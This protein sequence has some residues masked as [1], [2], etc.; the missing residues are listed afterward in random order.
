MEILQFI[1]GSIFGV[2][3][4]IT[5]K[6]IINLRSDYISYYERLDEFILLPISEYTF[7][8]RTNHFVKIVYN[9]YSFYVD[10]LKDELNIFYD[11]ELMIYKTGDNDKK[12]E[13]LFERFNVGFDYDIYHNITIINNTIISNNIINFDINPESENIETIEYIPSMDEILDKISKYGI[14]NLTQTD[15]DILK[16]GQ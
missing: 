4:I 14:D 9:N 6:K 12:L 13:H 7:V 15:L 10:L 5:I 2:F 11:E 16:N 3:L 1:L 8:S